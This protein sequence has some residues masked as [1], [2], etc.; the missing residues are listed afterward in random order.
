MATT[1]SLNNA[2]APRY[3][4]SRRSQFAIWW[5]EIDRVLLGLVPR[6]RRCVLGEKGQCCL[7]MQTQSGMKQVPMLLFDTASCRHS[8]LH[9]CW[10]HA[11]P[12]PPTPTPLPAAL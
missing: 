6:R 4:R 9:A 8:Q 7:T 12:H 5:R 11:A 1:P 3:R 2:A 10:M